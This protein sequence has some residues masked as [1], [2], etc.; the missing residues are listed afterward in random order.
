[1]R[2]FLVFF[3]FTTFLGSAFSK[4]S[5]PK[6]DSVVN[7]LEKIKE[8]LIQ[9]DDLEKITLNQKFSNT[10]ELLLD[11][12]NTLNY[13][14]SALKSVSVLSGPKNKFR[15]YTWPLE[16]SGSTFDYF[17]FTQY[18]VKKKEKKVAVVALQNSLFEVNHEDDV[19]YG[20]EQWRGA[21][22]YTIVPP[23]KKN[24]KKFLLLGWDGNDERSSKKLIEVISF[25]KKGIPSF[26]APVLKIDVGGS[27][28]VKYETKYRMEFEYSS[29]VAMLLRYD[30]DQKMV[31]FD[32]LIPS[33]E[34][35][36]SVKST[37]IPDFSYDGLFYKKGKWYLQKNLQMK[38]KKLP[39]GK[40]YS[41]ADL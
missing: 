15:I 27:K 32:H 30:S 39:K 8:Q 11:D 6:I 9:A 33:T 7:V 29:K 25:D 37:Y 17:G 35:L 26:G 20:S 1:M 10:L 38:N 12:Y 22:Y 2:Y 13:D 18:L 14:F 3:F 31:V 24:D 19:Q 5:Y 4:E 34:R 23:R 40:K 28:Q 36:K 41:P 21:L 16:L